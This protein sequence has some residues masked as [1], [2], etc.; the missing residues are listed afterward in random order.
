MPEQGSSGRNKSLIPELKERIAELEL[1]DGK[2]TN[3]IRRHQTLTREK[4]L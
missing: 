1:L 4:E 3:I 2:L